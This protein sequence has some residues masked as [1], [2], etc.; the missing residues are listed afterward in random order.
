MRFTGR[1]LATEFIPAADAG[2]K[3]LLIGLHGLGDSSAGYRW[4]PVALRMPW[5]NCLLVNA[6]DP[7]YGGYAWYDFS[8]NEAKG[9][10]RSRREL[11]ELLDAQRTRG[12]PTEET[13]MFG[14][15]Q[16]CVMTVDVGFRYPH[17]FAGLVGVSGYVHQL[18]KLIEERSAVAGRQR[19]LF[20]HGRMDPLV[21]FDQVRGQVERL[22]A[23]KFPIVWREFDKEH[24][25]CEEELQVIQQFIEE[26]FS[27]GL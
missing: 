2:S 5:L 17:R 14:F 1:M 15:S 18:E 13:V 23:A 22:Q 10:E 26:S 8:G 6:P 25:L 3:R 16:G 24:T 11:I 21:P 19:M 9:I 7:Y 20:T 27:G 4:L 12:F